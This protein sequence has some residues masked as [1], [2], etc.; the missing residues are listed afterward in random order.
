MIVLQYYYDSTSATMILYDYYDRESARGE[1]YPQSLTSD[2]TTY[3][4]YTYIVIYDY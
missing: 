3:I 1:A 2:T 4:P